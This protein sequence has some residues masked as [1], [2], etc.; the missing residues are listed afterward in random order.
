MQWFVSSV[1]EP[2][3]DPPDPHVFGPPGSGSISQRYGSGSGSFYQQA[4]IIRKTLIPTVL[5]LL[6]DFLSL[7]NDGN[8]PSKSNKQQNLKIRLVFLLAPWRSMTKIAGSGSGSGSISQT[9]GSADPVPDPYQNVVDLEHSLY[10]VCTR[11]YNVGKASY[12]IGTVCF[13]VL[14]SSVSSFFSR[15]PGRNGHSDTKAKKPDLFVNIIKCHF[16]KTVKICESSSF[17][18][19]S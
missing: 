1:P 8:V 18:M 16:I 14:W 9:Y 11:R 6:L 13:F 15:S 7:K 4:K 2:H 17:S 19:P 12:C 5:W 3:P 10:H